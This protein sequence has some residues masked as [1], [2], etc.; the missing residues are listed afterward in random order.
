MILHTIP[1]N[2]LRE[3]EVASTCWCE[4]RAVIEDGGMIVLHNA[5]D[6]R[7]LVEKANEILESNENDDG[8]SHDERTA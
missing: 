6:G 4:P 7:I 2:D 1:L 8:T 5:A 3:H